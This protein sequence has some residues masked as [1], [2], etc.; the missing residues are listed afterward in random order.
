MTSNPWLE[1]RVLHWAHQGGAREGP[2]ST[3]FAMRQAIDAGAHALELDV[4]MTAD[5]VLVVCHDA[6]VD[7]TTEGTGAIA[8]L[9]L[10]ELRR[11]DNAHWWVPGSVV[12]HDAP[13]EA[14]V[15]RGR[16]ADD[17]DFRI[18]TL[19]EVL[20]AFPDVL[21]NFDI[22]QTAP[23]VPSY[24]E[25]LAAV[26]RRFGRGD[27]VIVASFQDV[28]TARFR[29]AAPEFHTSVGAE[30][31]AAFYF[32][33]Q[34]GERPPPTPH[35]ALQVPRTFGDVVVVDERFVT[36]AHDAGLAVHVW[37]I[38][39]EDEMAGLVAL[40]VDGIM[41]DRPTALEGVLRA[42]AARWPG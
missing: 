29:A 13:P 7:R 11:L 31:T 9:T 26:L 3:L 33:V 18:A 38:D 30:A 16:A 20:E 19:E 39:D 5:G 21:C 41:T 17:P 2:S 22:K 24:E 8:E 27:D 23:A 12:D 35:V 14:Y 25:E 37:T 32:A 15:H 6:T 42:G 4:H 28:A 34:A 10:D 36:A 1:R 40:G